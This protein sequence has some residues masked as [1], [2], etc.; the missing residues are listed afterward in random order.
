MTERFKNALQQTERERD[1]K[2]VAQLFA[3]GASLSNLGGDHGNDATLFWQ[4]YLDQFQEIRSEFT[5]EIAGESTVALEWRSRGRM[6]DG[7]EIDY[8][9]ASLIDFEKDA[10]T[11]FRTYYDSAAFVRNA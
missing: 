6:A 4:T 10:V 5:S 2:H 7:R 1:P 11:A 8:R 3:A 9:G